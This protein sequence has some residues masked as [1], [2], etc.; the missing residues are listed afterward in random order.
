MSALGRRV[1]RGDDM[2]ESGATVA[3]APWHRFQMPAYSLLRSDRQGG[4]T[5]VNIGVG[6][7]NAK[8]ATDHL[9]A[10]AFPDQV[11]MYCGCCQQRWNSGML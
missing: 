9:A 8:N 11:V 1:K 5:I 6:P 4:I 3:A 7:S 10:Q 2:A